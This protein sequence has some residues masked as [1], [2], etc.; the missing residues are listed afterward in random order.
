L[1]ARSV[2]CVY[3]IDVLFV[4]LGILQHLFNRLH[5]LAEQVHVELFEFGASEYLREVVAILKGLNLDA[6]GLLA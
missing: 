6:S 2:K 5:R 3:L 4:D 1:D